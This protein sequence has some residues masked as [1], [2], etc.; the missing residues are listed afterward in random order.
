M[1]VPTAAEGLDLVVAVALDHGQQ[2]PVGAEEVLPDVGAGLDRVLLRL[3]VEHVAH[4][5]DQDAVDVPGQ[6]RI[7]LATPD[8]LDDIPARAP[9]DRLQL[10]DDLAVAA[11]RAVESLQVAVDHEGEVV[12]ALTSGDRQGAQRL[13]LIHLAVAQERPDPTAA[14][15]LDAPVVEVSIEAGLVDRGQRTDAHGDRGELP[16]VGHQSRMGIGAQTL[17]GHDLLAEMV[18]LVLRKPTLEV[19]TGVDARRRVALVEDLVAHPGRVLAP[20][21]VV[22]AHLVQARRGRVRGQMATDARRR[23]VGAQDHGDGI[24]ADHAPDAPLHLLITRELGLLLGR[25]GVDVAGLGERRQTDVQLACTLE[26]PIEHEL[27]TGDAIRADDGVERIDPVV[28][29]SQGPGRAAAA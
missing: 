3:T 28:R 27:G 11:H 9:E 16:E 13:R 8:D 10:L 20:E 15:V 22:E 18:E 26:Q 1:V 6:Q 23:G 24:P 17:T 5:L 14:G 2:P 4:P 7:P 21:E 19:R 12:Q 25:D 29:L